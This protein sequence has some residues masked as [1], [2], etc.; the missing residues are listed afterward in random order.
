MYMHSF[1]LFFS[2]FLCW[3]ISDLRKCNYSCNSYLLST[4][5]DIVNKTDEKSLPLWS[6]HILS[7]ETGDNQDEVKQT[8]CR[9]VIRVKEEDKADKRV[10]LLEQGF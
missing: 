4:C 6:L 9:V 2:Q 8:G 5:N 1:I 3:P 10:R 7:Q